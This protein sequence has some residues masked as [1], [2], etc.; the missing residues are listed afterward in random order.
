V[1]AIVHKPEPRAPEPLTG[2]A[3]A[4]SGIQDPGN[5]GTII[6]TA[7]WFGITEL[8]CSTDCADVYN[9]KVIQATMGSFARVNITYTQLEA[10]IPAQKNIPVYAAVLNGEPITGVDKAKKGI[11][12]IGNESKGIS[13]PV[14]NLCTHRVSIPRKGGAESLNA[15]VACGILLANL[16]ESNNE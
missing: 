2:W 9:S 11:L 1:L 15:A 10:Y 8:I 6:R 5:L 14:M 3:I 4:L 7:D 12:V 13:E 16:T